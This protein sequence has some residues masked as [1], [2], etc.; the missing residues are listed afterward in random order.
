[1]ALAPAG[2]ELY[3]ANAKGLGAG[4]NPG[5]SVPGSGKPVPPDQYSGSMIKGTLSI[6]D[7]PRTA[8]QLRRLTQRVIANNGVGQRANVRN[9][10]AAAAQH[11]VPAQLGGTSPLKHVIYIVNENRTYDQVL[12]DV[13]GANGDASLTLFVG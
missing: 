8:S 12:G 3:V 4:P 11:V 10:D 13:N 6:I 2:G 5:G 1:V 7:A 9:T